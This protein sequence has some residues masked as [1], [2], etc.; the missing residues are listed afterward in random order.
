MPVH[1][2]RDHEVERGAG[3]PGGAGLHCGRQ[4]LRLERPGAAARGTVRHRA[5]RD[6]ADLLPGHPCLHRRRAGRAAAGPAKSRDGLAGHDPGAWRDPGVRRGAGGQLRSLPRLLLAWLRHLR[7]RHLHP[8]GRDRVARSPPRMG[9]PAGCRGLRAGGRSV[10]SHPGRRRRGGAGLRALDWVAAALA[11]AAA[12]A[13]LRAA[14]PNLAHTTRSPGARSRPACC[15]GSGSSSPPGLWAGSWPWGSR[16]P[17]PRIAAPAPGS[18]RWWW[19]RSLWGTWA[20]VWGRGSS[21]GALRPNWS[22]GVAQALGGLALALL[23]LPTGP[24]PTA[25]LMTGVAS[26][27]ADGGRHPPVGAPSGGSSGLRPCLR[28]H[29]HGLGRGRPDRPWLAG[30]LRDRTGGW[31]SGLAL[32]LGGSLV[33]LAA[34]AVGRWTRA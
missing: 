7:G 12:L 34:L 6:G 29:L 5:R 25:L 24:V 18:L 10:R 16:S 17:S 26:D 23:L 1:D 27:T 4:P 15:C 8:R 2:P 13:L 22:V 3:G 11:G 31:E 19:R 20:A 9:R 33:A 21:L 30:G 14:R 32:A 28:N